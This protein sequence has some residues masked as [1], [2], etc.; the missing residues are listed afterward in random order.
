MI[1]IVVLVA[2]SA[3]AFG[4]AIGIRI[5]AEPGAHR[6]RSARAAH[7][8]DLDLTPPHGTPVVPH[9]PRHARADGTVAA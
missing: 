5:G 1:T 2:V 6:P 7:L 9:V 3:C 4:I 8:R